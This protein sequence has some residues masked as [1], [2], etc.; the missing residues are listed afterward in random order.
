M[1][2]LSRI[3]HRA[4]SPSG[5]RALEPHQFRAR[6]VSPRAHGLCPLVTVLARSR[7][8]RRALDARVLVEATDGFL[9]LS[10]D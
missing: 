7:D 6:P 2:V 10:E 5:H 1:P 8:T 3:L 9:S 4:F